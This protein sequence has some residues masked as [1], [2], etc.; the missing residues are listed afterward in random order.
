MSG[1]GD[2]DLR[3][4]EAAQ[5][6]SAGREE[7]APG[8][9]TATIHAHLLKLPIVI[10]A[11]AALEQTAENHLR[12]VNTQITRQAAV[13]E[14]YLNLRDDWLPASAPTM[15]HVSLVTALLLRLSAAQ[16]PVANLPILVNSTSTLT[17]A[18]APACGPLDSA[19]FTELNT[20]IN[21]DVIKT[22]VTFGDSW[23]STGSNGT[24]PLPP[25]LHPPLP[26][27]GAR[28]SENRRATNGFMWSERLAAD[29]N[30]KL[31]DYSWGGAIID[32]FAYN[33]TSPLNATGVPRSDFIA[34][35]GLFFL[36]GHFLDALVPSQ[37][38]YTVA[39][40][41]NDNG[42]FS[43]AGGD[44]DIA[45][46]TYVTKL[47]ELQ[48]SGASNILIHAMYTSHPETDLLQTRVFAYLRDSHIAN[49]THFAFVNLERLFGTIAAEPASFGY[50]GNA[51]CLV[52][53][54]TIVGGC[55][56]PD[57]SVFYI[58]GHPSMMTHGLINEYTA[59]V[60]KQC[61]V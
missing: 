57:H 26:S 36:Q 53:A 2:A 45:Y 19:N 10:A 23:T 4:I 34:Q 40:G 24:V 18:I 29:L 12:A 51:T 22:L 37:T 46:N 28:N 16:T 41:I 9:V 59:A 7:A 42:Q 56:D 21:L 50:A 11:A 52:S 43:I 48:A 17:L 20:G 38:L 54:N 33:T 14:I 1:E 8:R 61:V 58:P 27:A 44:M 35:A 47:G 31:L 25:I 32:N 6:M 13:L 3:G 5:S 55:A 49:G 39:F 30:A 60:L 15:L